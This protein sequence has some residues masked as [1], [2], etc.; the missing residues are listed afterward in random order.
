MSIPGPG[1]NAVIN[2]LQSAAAQAGSQ[3]GGQ[4]AGKPQLDDSGAADSPSFAHALM[5]SI[6]RMDDMKKTAGAEGRAF[7]RGEP[8]VGLD[9]VMVDMQKAGLAFEMGI[10]VRNRM[11]S[12]Y[13]EIMNMQV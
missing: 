11:V 13:R 5:A 7:E 2:Q 12:S 3:V 8:G 9:T 6:D 4:A 1:I 10:Q